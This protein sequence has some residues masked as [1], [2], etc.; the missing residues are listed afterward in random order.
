MV[1]LTKF[2][3]EKYK[4]ILNLG[5]CIVEDRIT[6]L[7]GKNESGKTNILEGLEKIN[8][9]SKFE[10]KEKT[11][12]EEGS[13]KIICNFKLEEADMN[14][15]ISEFKDET[16]LELSETQIKGLEKQGE[17][18]VSVEEDGYTLSGS[19]CDSLNKLISK[20]S[21]ELK[22]IIQELK[23]EYEKIREKTESLPNFPEVDIE[24]DFYNGAKKIKEFRTAQKD[25]FKAGEKVDFLENFNFELLNKNKDFVY[26]IL[27][28]FIP[29][30]ILFKEFDEEKIPD[31]MTFDEAKRSQFVKDLN[32]ITNGG[33]DIDKIIEKQNEGYWVQNFQGNFSAK[34]SKDFMEYWD[35]AKTDKVNEVEIKLRIANGK[36]EFYVRNPRD[37]K[38]LCPSQR[39][40]GFQWFLSFYSRVCAN[41][42]DEKNKIILIDEPG[43]FLHAKAQRSVLK[44]LNDMFRDD[45]IIYSTHSPYLIEEDKLE[46]IRL[47]EKGEDG[48]S[49][50]LNKF[51]DSDDQD[52]LT[53][54]LTAIGHDIFSGITFDNHKK[55]ILVEGISD[56]LILKS[57]FEKIKPEFLSNHYIIP[58][59]G[60]DS[61]PKYIPFFIGW[62]LEFVV[63]VDSDAKG[64]KIKK[65]LRDFWLIDENKILEISDVSG[66]SIE[67]LFKHEEYLTKLLG[68]PSF[69]ADKKISKQIN[70]SNKVIAAKNLQKVNFD[71][72]ISTQTINKFKDILEKIDGL[73]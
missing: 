6:V 72:D 50:V 18:I 64:K 12:G 37:T 36:I 62:G 25:K 11:L 58:M 14:E 38:E 17:L 48:Y 28:G 30:I 67:D 51:Y 8:E 13:P 73:L 23:N 70:D 19:L 54:I 41:I 52:T 24:A 66:E 15:I 39:S 3:I 33:L 71:S 21:E 29:E 32:K 9:E 35:V 69:E 56:Y 27:I 26:E 59:R 49:R 42:N 10:E 61:I 16:S 46:R 4:S 31:S 2:N 1:K 34:I 5:E 7:A 53:P 22:K 45:Q 60:A 65:D 47:V 44:V 43:L 55:C 68:R 20:N 57:F 63:L 40:K